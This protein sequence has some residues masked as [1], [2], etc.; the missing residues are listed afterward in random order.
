[1]TRSLARLALGLLL[2]GSVTLPAAADSNWWNA[3][4]TARRKLTFNN[5]AQ[6]TNLVGFPVMV[7]LDSS[8]ID[9]AK[10]QNAGQDLRFVDADNLTRS[11]S[12]T[13]QARPTCG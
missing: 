3:S 11:S 13:R 7:R 4:W 2:A 9:Y 12:G 6:A 5:A 1:V 8:R 10:I